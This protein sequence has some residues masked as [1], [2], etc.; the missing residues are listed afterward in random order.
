M[1]KLL[2]LFFAAAIAFPALAQKKKDLPDLKQEVVI[3]KKR[4]KVYNNWLS[5][6]GGAGYNTQIPQLQFIG[7]L[8]YNFH[9]KHNYFQLGLVLSGDEFGSYN[10]YNFH[11]GYGK[12]IENAK[13]N[14][15]VFGGLSYTQ[16]YYKEGKTYKDDPYKE[17]GLYLNTQLIKK[18]TYDVGL[19][20]G[21]IADYNGKR[22]LGGLTAVVYFSGA[23]KG[24]KE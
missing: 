12:R 19:G 7:Q 4:F 17:A 21:A 2:L 8:D 16:G 14:F 22:F 20:I 9:L 23:Y 13:I 15:S 5:G 1:K 3:N 10:N 11:G 24:K 6:G 18:I